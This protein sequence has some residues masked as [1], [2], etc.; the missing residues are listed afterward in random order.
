MSRRDSKPPT[1]PSPR[2]RH[3]VVGS[4][5]ASIPGGVHVLVRSGE[6]RF[7]SDQNRQRGFWK[8][9]DHVTGQC[10]LAVQIDRGST[11]TEQF[12]DESDATNEIVPDSLWV[13]VEYG[14]S[15]DDRVIS[16]LGRSTARDVTRCHAKPPLRLAMGG[17]C[18]CGA[19]ETCGLIPFTVPR[20]TIRQPARHH[21]KTEK[22]ER[23]RISNTEH[24]RRQRIGS[25]HHTSWFLLL[26]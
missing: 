15:P 17:I 22:R 10:R 24:C 8:Q 19:S 5:A 16:A 11:F 21:P 23:A 7:L 25:S 3:S 14:G 18:A 9:C 6:I 13:A 26:H 4:S 2:H 20:K 12:N 1:S